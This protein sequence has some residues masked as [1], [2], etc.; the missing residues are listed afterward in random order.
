MLEEIFLSETN[1]I[2]F[3]PLLEMPRL[4]WVHVSETMRPTLAEVEA[5]AG[6]GIAYE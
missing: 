6:F 5:R 1:V 4:K 2:D 3:S